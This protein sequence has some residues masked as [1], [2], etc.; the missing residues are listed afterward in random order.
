M[1]EL[2]GLNERI[3]RSH[4]NNGYENASQYYNILFCLSFFKFVS[5]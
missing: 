4:G 1:V 3:T 2:D 5:K